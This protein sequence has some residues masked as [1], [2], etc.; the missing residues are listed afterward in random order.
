MLQAPN[1]PKS[2][3]ILVTK[4]NG[5]AMHYYIFPKIHKKQAKFPY[6]GNLP[7]CLIA[8]IHREVEQEEGDQ[9][10]LSMHISPKM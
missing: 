3:K 9:Q 2:W 4:S 10:P 8:K 1:D 7:I 6:W 5:D